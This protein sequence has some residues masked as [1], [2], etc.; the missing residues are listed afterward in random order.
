MESESGRS[1]VTAI[2]GLLVRARHGIRGRWLPGADVRKRVADFLL[3]P[4]VTHAG[5]EAYREA[6]GRAG[7]RLEKIH[8][9]SA[10][11]VLELRVDGNGGPD[12][13]PPHSSRAARP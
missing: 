1:F 4:H 9:I 12:R 5:V 13:P 6:A 10:M 7:L 8:R 3:V 2:T 11:N